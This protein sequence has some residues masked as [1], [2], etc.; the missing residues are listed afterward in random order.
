MFPGAF[1]CRILPERIRR[2]APPSRVL[3]PHI[4]QFFEKTRGARM[5]GTIDDPERRRQQRAVNAGVQCHRGDY[6]LVE[7]VVSGTGSGLNGMRI[8]GILLY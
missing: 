3:N 1:E 7:T 2:P 6:R 8:D 5:R 4:E